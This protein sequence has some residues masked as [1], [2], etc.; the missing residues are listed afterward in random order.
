[1]E[2]P[3]KIFFSALRH[4][5]NAEGQSDKWWEVVQLAKLDLS[6]NELRHLPEE[7]FEALDSLQVAPLATCK[8]TPSVLLPRNRVP[9]RTIGAS[10]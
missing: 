2:V 8:Q 7:L 4:S 9:S 5:W 1:L 10:S 3:K 6:H